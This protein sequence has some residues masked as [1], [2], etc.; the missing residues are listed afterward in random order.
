MLKKGKTS[1]LS[2][3]ELQLAYRSLQSLQSTIVLEEQEPS[4]DDDEKPDFA[5]VVA[6]LLEM[7]KARLG[8][9]QV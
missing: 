5:E 4:A 1:G 3:L 9:P 2:D 6:G 7:M 8:D